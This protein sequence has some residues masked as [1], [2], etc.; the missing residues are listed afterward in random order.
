MSSG[1]H[2]VSDEYAFVTTKATVS[3][4]SVMK[5]KI[6]GKISLSSNIQGCSKNPNK[7]ELLITTMIN[8]QL[9]ALLL[10][11]GAKLIAQTIDLD[12]NIKSAAYLDSATIVLLNEFYE[13][14]V[15]RTESG[16]SSL[17]LPQDTQMADEVDAMEQDENQQWM[18]QVLDSLDQRTQLQEQDL[19]ASFDPELGVGAWK[20]LFATSS[21]SL[22]AVSAVYKPFMDAFLLKHESKTENK[23]QQS[24]DAKNQQT[25]TKV[26]SASKQKQETST[27]NQDMT[28]FLRDFIK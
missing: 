19:L 11:T 13:M 2:C 26:K 28:A 12:A 4:Y 21:H 6:V 7:S 22:A 23:N 3:L 5:M 9:V 17:P 10:G 15:I 16:A 8:N 25:S 1:I 14:Y 24:E 20:K 18:Q 27:L